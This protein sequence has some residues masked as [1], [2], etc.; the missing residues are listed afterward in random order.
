MEKGNSN[1]ISLEKIR[2]FQ[3]QISSV[4]DKKADLAQ[5]SHKASTQAKEEDLFQSLMKKNEEAKSRRAAE[6][7]KSNISVLKSYKIKN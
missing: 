1:L 7:A 5:D 4:Q 6:R 3:S 2:L